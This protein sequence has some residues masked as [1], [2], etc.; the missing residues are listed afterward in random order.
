MKGQLDVRMEIELSAVVA[1][2]YHEEKEPLRLMNA[3][4]F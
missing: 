4:I 3:R 1:G 2:S